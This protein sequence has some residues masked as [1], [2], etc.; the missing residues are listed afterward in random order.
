MLWLSLL[1]LRHFPAPGM[2]WEIWDKRKK[3]RKKWKIVFL[4]PALALVFTGSTYLIF[5]TSLKVKMKVTQLYPTFWDPWAVVHEIF[6]ARILEWV[7]KIP[8][9][10]GSSQ[11]RDQ[12][13]LSHIAGRF[14]ASWTIREIQEHW[15]KQSIPSPENL[16]DPGIKLGSPALQVDSLQPK[17]PGKPYLCRDPEILGKSEPGVRRVTYMSCSPS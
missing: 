9:S 12:T 8:F 11:P 5:L 6:Q 2:N 14:F 7:V 15:N 3:E 10:R 17:Q 1:M 16:P 13:Q 4:I